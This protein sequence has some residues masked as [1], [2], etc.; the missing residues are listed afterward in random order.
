MFIMSSNFPFSAFASFATVAKPS[1]S[2]NHRSE[3]VVVCAVW[4]QVLGGVDASRNTR[5][6]I[7][8]SHVVSCVKSLFDH[9]RAMNKA[10]ANTVTA[11]V[12]AARLAVVDWIDLQVRS[13]R[14]YLRSTVHLSRFF[15]GYLESTAEYSRF[16]KIRS[17][18][19]ASTAEQELVKSSPCSIGFEYG[20]PTLKAIVDSSKSKGIARLR[21]VGKHSSIGINNTFWTVLA[22]NREAHYLLTKS[23]HRFSLSSDDLNLHGSTFN[24]IGVKLGIKE[25][26]QMIVQRP[27]RPRMRLRLRFGSSQGSISSRDH[28]EKHMKNTKWSSV[29]HAIENVLFENFQE[30]PEQEHL[31][32][33]GRRGA[34][35]RFYW[36]LEPVSQ[37]ARRNSQLFKV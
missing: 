30:L 32:L 10:Q 20:A 24:L 7:R 18:G 28:F 23:F 8:R 13:E 37:A 14:K 19:L 21:G 27:G 5:G 26:P 9:V 35:D 17:G 4:N 12:R 31:V 15:W 33:G 11:D 3:A 29:F 2:V 6:L 22:K 16:F 1:P 36:C 25:G 34:F